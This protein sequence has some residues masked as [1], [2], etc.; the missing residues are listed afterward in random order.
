MPTQKT[1]TVYKFDELPEESQQLALDNWR[2]SGMTDD[3]FLQDYIRE[4]AHELI[5]DNGIVA[6]KQGYNDDLDVFYSLSNSQ[7]DGAMFVG[8]FSWNKYPNITINIKQ[9]GNYSHSNSKEIDIQTNDE[10]IDEL[11]DTEHDK[12]YQ[13]FEAIYQSICKELEQYGYD[14]IEYQNSDE[15]IKEQIEANDYNFTLNGK[16]DS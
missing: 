13:E 9:R 8:S 7:G 16:I 15:C 12:I 5:T 11:S 14:Q 3:P 1:Y 2:D 6:H 10:A 4:R